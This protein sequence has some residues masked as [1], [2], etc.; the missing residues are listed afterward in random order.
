MLGLPM[1]QGICR[2]STLPAV[3]ALTANRTGG[4][5]GAPH[6]DGVHGLYFVLY[7][8]PWSP[9]IAESLHTFTALQPPLGETKCPVGFMNT[10]NTAKLK[11]AA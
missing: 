1:L 5:P 10:A 7:F 11:S 9:V 8:L 4:I 6:V 2:G 3:R